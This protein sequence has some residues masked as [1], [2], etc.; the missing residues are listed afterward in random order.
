MLD[1]SIFLF[2]KGRVSMPLRKVS[3]AGTVRYSSVVRTWAELTEDSGLPG[4]CNSSPQGIQC[5]LVA[6]EGNA[7]TKYTD[8]DAS[9]T[10][11]NKLI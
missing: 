9:K 7:Y 1:I 11:I 8:K 2:F 5:P 3:F 6:F 10:S 4:V